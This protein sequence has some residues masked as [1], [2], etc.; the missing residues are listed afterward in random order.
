METHTVVYSEAIKTSI[1]FSRHWTT[2]HLRM[3]SQNTIAKNS[4]DRSSD[5][6]QRSFS[7]Y[8]PN[9]ELKGDIDIFI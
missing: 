8:G 7:V 2:V 6:T 9:S 5:A 3:I 4:T 1:L